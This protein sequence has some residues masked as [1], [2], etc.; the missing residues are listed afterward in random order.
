MNHEIQK[1]LDGDTPKFNQGEK[2]KVARPKKEEITSQ[3]K[4]DGPTDR[5]LV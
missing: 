5:K 4:I 3:I 1:G 2:N